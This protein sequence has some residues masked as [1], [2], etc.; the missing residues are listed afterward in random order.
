M[1]VYVCA[2][3][4]VH[5]YVC[6]HAGV[7]VCY[8]AIPEPTVF[9]VFTVVCAPVLPMPVLLPACVFVSYLQHFYPNLIAFQFVIPMKTSQVSEILL[10]R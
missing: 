5:A 10:K 9:P 2:C 6:M 1:H 4:Y 3:V 7:H 8:P